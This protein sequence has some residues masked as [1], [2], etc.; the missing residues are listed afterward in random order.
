MSLEEVDWN[1]LPQPNN[2]GAADHL[3]AASLPAVNLKSTHNAADKIDSSNSTVDLSAL[4]GRTV[5]YIYPMTGRPDTPLPNGWN[6]I[7]GARGCTPQS[8]AFRDHMQELTELG[9]SQLF[10]LSTQST[11][12]QQEAVE[13][14]HLPYNL[15]SDEQLKFQSALKLPTLTVDGKTLLKRLTLIVDDSK[16]T[17]HFYPVF[18]PDKNPL[19]VIQWIKDNKP[20]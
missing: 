16:I 4:T 6:D 5:I 8:C 15:L 11:D 13:R 14:L 18:P 7:P 3:T 19:D 17:H 1:A 12:Y 2:D 20:L 9:V 10:G